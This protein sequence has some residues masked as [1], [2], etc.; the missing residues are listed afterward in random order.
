MA[1]FIYNPRVLKYVKDVLRNYD[2][3]FYVPRDVSKVKDSDVLIV[4]SEGLRILH[5]TVGNNLPRYFLVNGDDASIYRP[6][7]NAYGIKEV[8]VIQVGIDVGKR[9]AYVVLCDGVLLRAGYAGSLR[10]L[11]NSINLLNNYL[12]PSKVIIKIGGYVDELEIHLLKN[13]LQRNC[14]VFLIDEQKSS[15]KSQLNLCGLKIKFTDDIH[16]ALNIALRD[17][18]KLEFAAENPTSRAGTYT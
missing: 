11:I 3:R 6:I 13:H 8:K 17:G 7:L 14:E 9:L 1:L 2:L 18:I 15:A 16:A 12:R 10:E 4:D 5:S